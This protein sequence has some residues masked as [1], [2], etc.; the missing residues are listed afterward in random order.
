MLDSFPHTLKQFGLYA[1]ARTLMDLLKLAEQGVIDSLGSLHDAGRH[2]VCKGRRDFGPY[3]LAFWEHFLGIDVR[4][5]PT[6]NGAIR[7]APAFE[8]WLQEQTDTASRRVSWIGG[9]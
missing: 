2:L 4:N 3:T 5:H 7:N 6:I 9:H 8:H 1:D